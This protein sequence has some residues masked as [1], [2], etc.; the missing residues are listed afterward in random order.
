MRVDRPA[1]PASRSRNAGS[2]A[3]QTSRGETLPRCGVGAVRRHSGVLG[4]LLL[5]HPEVGFVDERGGIERLVFVPAAA[6]A[7]RNAME[8]VV[9]GPEQF[10]RRVRIARRG[11]PEEHV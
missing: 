6:L 4:A 1:E 2:T 7:A 5:P 11:R 9:H 10:V 3:G 8:P